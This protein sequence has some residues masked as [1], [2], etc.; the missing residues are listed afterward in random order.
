M[1]MMDI[2]NAGLGGLRGAGGGQSAALNAALS[3][4][5]G[6]SGG[7]KALVQA[8]QQQGLGDIVG[9]WVGTGQNLPI[10]PDQLRQVL[11]SQQ[12]SQF[13][14]QAGIAPESA[15]SALASLL[16]SLI[17]KLTPEGR[18]P[19]DDQ[20]PGLDVLAGLLK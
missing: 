3:L 11:G 5:G 19:A 10:A 9:S 14:A 7:L 12:M 17:D 6:Q 8:F 16:P 4:L 15:G 2:V 18:V 20:L 1:D 13:A